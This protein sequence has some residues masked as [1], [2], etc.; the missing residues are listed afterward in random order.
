MPPLSILRALGAFAVTLL[1]AFA[2]RGNPVITEIMA[3]N[4]SLIADEDGAYSDWI[5]LHNPGA[6]AVNLTDWALTDDA[7]NLT[8]WKFPAVT[9]QPG[10]FLTVWAS[11]KNKRTPGLPLHTNFSLAKS[12]EYLALVQPN[13]TTVEQQFAPAFPAMA[14]NE[15]YGLQFTTTSFVA[16]GA[17]ARYLVPPNGTLGTTWT[18]PGFN[19]TSWA[20]GPTGL[21]FGLLVPGITV[22]QV[23]AA[24]AFGPVNSVATTD[25]LL[26]LPANS[27]NIASQTTVNAGAV[28]FLG[29]GGDGHY[30]ANAVLPNGRAEPYGLKATGYLQIVT[31]GAYTFGLSSDDGGRI[32]IDGVAVMTDD[33][34]HGVEDH[35]GT[36]TLAAGLHTFEVIMWEG[37]GGDEVEFYAGAGTFAGWQPAFRLVGDTANGGLAAFTL[38]GGSG[39]NVVATNIGGMMQNVNA[40]CYVRAPFTASG[41]GALTSLSLKMRYND[42]Y[43]AYLNNGTVIAQRNAPGVP[44]YNSAA[45]AVRSEAASAVADPV[46]VTAFLP[47]L[48]NGSN[49]LAIQG[50][51]TTAADGTF[52]VLPELIGGTLNAGA[53]AVFF[54]SVKATPGSINGA[55]SL[56]GKVADTTFS[57]KRGFFTA[58]FQLSI[59]T[60]TS[61]AT[62]R[63]TTDRSTPTDT[64]GTVYTGPLTV[65]GTTVIRAA[66][67][68]PGYQPTDVDTQTYIFTADVITQSAAGTPPAGWPVGPIN[69]QV[70]DYGM[71]PDIVNS[72]DPTIGGATVVQNA[73]KA[74]STISIVTDQANLTDPGTGIIVNPGGRGFA[75]ERAASIEMINPPDALHPNGTSEFQTGCGIRVRG[76]YSRSTDNPKHGF[77]IH[78]RSDYGAAKL[79]YPLFGRFGTDSFDQIDLR[80][81]ENYSWSFGG[82]GNN[83]FLREEAS[84]RAQTEM[85]QLGSHVRYV[86]CY[87]NGQ[88]FGLFD[89]DERTEAS[90]GATYLPGSKAD[91]D[92]VKCEQ[93]SGYTTGVTDGNLTAW[94]DLWTKSRA[95][96]ASPTNANYFKMQGRAADGVT[97]TADPVLLDVDNLIDYMLVTFWHGNLDGSTSAFLGNDRSN[98]WFGLRNRLGTQ[99]FKFF[100][101]DAEHSFFNTGEDRTGPFSDPGTG[102]WNNFSYSAPMF[103]D[104]DLRPNIEYKMR[105]ADRV[106]KHLF[107]GGQLSAAKWTARFNSLASI[108]DSAIVAESARWGD[109]KTA[110]PLNRVNWLGARDYILNNYVSVRGATVLAQL[111]ADG[112]YPAIDAPVLNPFGGYVATGS[113]VVMSAPAGTIYYMTDGT[114][115]RLLGGAVKAGALIYSSSTTN[116]TLVPLGA[117]WKYKDDGSNQGTAWRASAFTDTTWT[118]GAAELGYGDGDEATTVGG[119]PAGARYATTYFRKSFSVTNAN[120]ITAG[121]IHIR[122]DDAAAVYING[123]EVARTAGLAA[124]P[125]FDFY[126]AAVSNENAEADYAI[127][128]SVLVNGANTIAVEIHQRAP[129]SSDISFNLSLTASRTAVPAPYFVTGSGVKNLRVRAF[130][131]GTSAWSALADATYLVNTDPAAAANLAISE[132]MYHP[133]DPSAAEI[134]AGFLNSDDFEFIEF[135][136]LGPRAI[137]LAGLYFYGSIGFDFAN[138][139]LPRTLAAGARILLVS[140]KAAFD[141]RY[142]TGKP[143]AGE[144]SGHLNNAGEQIILFNSASTAISDVTYGTAAGWPPEADGTGYSLVRIQPD[145]TF[146]GDNTP[147]NWRHSTALGGNPGATDALNYPA[148]KTANSVTSDTADTDGDGLSNALEYTLGGVLPLADTARLPRLG[149]ATFTVLGLPGTYA[150]LTFTRR[151]A[152][153][154]ATFAIETGSSLAPTNWL[155]NGVFVSATPNGDGTET[156]LYRAPNPQ[157][158]NG[159]KFFLHL[160][161]QILP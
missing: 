93:D 122:Y 15:S 23:Q 109:S 60:L 142:G 65:S 87:V 96:Y 100:V 146:I 58:P 133:A 75:W 118:S 22:R 158:A 70:L 64:N 69:G 115:P 66:A 16:A 45:T 37:G 88:Y 34:N 103:L 82:D 90:F 3:D 94:Q 140:N 110:V 124:D 139:L 31:A 143:V 56:L 59:T 105:W 63:Y 160:K 81:A 6:A 141:F 125:A 47:Q 78:F 5:E 2:A 159:P 108:V 161:T 74:L 18:A 112:L 33:T 155:P 72:A 134:T 9:M 50:L 1:L 67:F 132:I 24:A 51:N 44:A 46:N 38:P 106:H 128:P 84:R 136:N 101:H 86:H 151:F 79:S 104:Q 25:A 98:N 49:V 129:D 26:A 156:A 131:S 20:S 148:W 138:S 83:T 61:G 121:T 39:S 102:N 8:K 99:G 76:G 55:Y 89:F 27:P 111:R 145:G 154:D 95:H 97:P 30:G 120:Q 77:H 147:A 157:A 12:G 40:S 130:D 113:E 123:T 10:A 21:G 116:E 48:L 127:P 32:K 29:D 41:A 4:V 73:L 54:D 119:G 11:A 152:A 14:A 117:T 53:Q 36:V 57:V 71:D 35:T 7:A 92:V 149:T 42:G 68:K 62:I 17:T 91:F 85:G 114:D 137:D 153:D 28:N 144:Y 150:T 19:H 52:L 13:G 126:A 107:N 135:V 80:T 43:V